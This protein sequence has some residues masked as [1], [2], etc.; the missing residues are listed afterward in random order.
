M[1]MMMIG[2]VLFLLP[3]CIIRSGQTLDR[4]MYPGNCVKMDTVQTPTGPV[5]NRI[6]YPCA[7]ERMEGKP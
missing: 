3:G 6:L 4:G 2:I 1:K 5:T 7:V